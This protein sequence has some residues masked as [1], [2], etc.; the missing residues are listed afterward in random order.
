M[1]INK[2]SVAQRKL[3]FALCKDVG[4]TGD[5]AKDKA[6]KKFKL[7]SFKDIES[8][9]ISQLID[10]LQERSE[11]PKEKHNHS[12][13]LEAKSNKHSFYSCECGTIVIEPR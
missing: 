3:F 4:L 1:T 6:K 2:A 12:F 11:K 8:K 13:E 7:K 5:Q 9:Q 10:K